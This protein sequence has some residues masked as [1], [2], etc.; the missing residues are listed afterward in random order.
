[1]L[2]GNRSI[3]VYGVILAINKEALYEHS[4]NVKVWMVTVHSIAHY[5]LH[6]TGE[7]PHHQ[8]TPTLH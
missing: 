5:K 1:M 7:M 3:V 2:H 8:L 4:R 6:N